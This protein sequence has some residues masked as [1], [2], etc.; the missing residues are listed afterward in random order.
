MAAD[1][2]RMVSL[3]GDS[4]SSDCVVTTPYVTASSAQTTATSAPWSDRKLDKKNLSG[5]R[6]SETEARA[7]RRGARGVYRARAAIDP[8]PKGGRSAGPGR[9][10]RPRAPPAARPPGRPWALRERRLR[11]ARRPSE[12]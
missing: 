4:A 1:R 12:G 5:L 7:G 11:V 2:P 9:R 3:S 8:A 10:R 6:Q